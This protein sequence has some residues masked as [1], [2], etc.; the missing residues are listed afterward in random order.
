MIASFR[1]LDQEEGG[2]V[3][4]EKAPYLAAHS[5]SPKGWRLYARIRCRLKKRAYSGG[6]RWLISLI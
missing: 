5:R 3:I 2:G 1:S 4:P 6:L